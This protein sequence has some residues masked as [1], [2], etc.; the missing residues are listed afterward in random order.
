MQFKGIDHGFVTE[1][2]VCSAIGDTCIKDGV[3][4]KREKNMGW[5]AQ[6]PDFSGRETPCSTPERPSKTPFDVAESA[7]NTKPKPGGMLFMRDTPTTIAPDTA[8]N[9]GGKTS[10][11]DV[12]EGAKTLNDLIEAKDMRFWQG[13]I[14]KAVY[15]LSERSTRATDGSAS[16]I[17]ELNKI[18]YYV[19]RRLAQLSREKKC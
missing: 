8:Q 4:Y 18:R 1:F 6:S 16:E 13:E 3:L 5:V 17:R 15:A 19:D 11:Y 7:Y 9:N 10:Y 12:P 14:F 2:P